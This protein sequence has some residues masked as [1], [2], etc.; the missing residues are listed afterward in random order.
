M[1]RAISLLPSTRARRPPSARDRRLE[2]ATVARCMTAESVYGSND[3]GH[4]LGLHR[5]VEE[6]ALPQRAARLD[7]D[8]TK[9][10]E[11]ELEVAVHTLN[12]DA[13]SFRQ[14][15]EA[16][17]GDLAGVARLVEETVRTRGKQHNPVTGSGGMLLGTVTR[18]GR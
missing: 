14:M 13:A 3:V 8:R 6:V 7:A 5:V 4:S 12:V 11:S 15:E 9:H 2:R 16:S 1:T 17:Q 10:F 18:V